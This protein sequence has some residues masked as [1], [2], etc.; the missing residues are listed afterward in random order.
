MAKIYTENGPIFCHI[1]S[2]LDAEGEFLLMELRIIEFFDI[3]LWGLNGGF[4]LI[5]AGNDINKAFSYVCSAVLVFTKFMHGND[6][7]TV[8][9][10]LSFFIENFLHFYSPF[11]IVDHSR[12]ITLN[13]LPTRGGGISPGN[14][15][16]TRYSVEKLD[17]QSFAGKLN[18]T[19]SLAESRAF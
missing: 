18:S 10:G 6:F 8:L 5:G 19:L 4:G 13:F 2:S 17:N 3:N 9:D 12:S 14:V 7:S 15:F 1:K 11:T 16:P